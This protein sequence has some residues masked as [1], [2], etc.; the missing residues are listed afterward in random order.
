MQKTELIMGMPITITLVGARD[1]QVVQKIFDYF[2]EVDARY[3]TYKDTSE[4][5][6]INA[7]LPRSQWS[8]EMKRVLKLCE[9][10][11]HETDGCFDIEHDGLIDPSGLVK[12]WA[13]RRA[14]EKLLAK[15]LD[16]FSIEAGG[17]IEVHG[18]SNSGEQ[19]RIGI[20]NPFDREQIIKV[21]GVRDQ[22]VATSGTYIRGQHIYDPKQGKPLTDIAS[23]TVI[24]PNIYEADRFAT[25]AFAMGVKGIDFIEKLKGFEGY[26]IDTKGIATMTSGFEEYTK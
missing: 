17:D 12:G 11:K 19:W 20:R 3:S 5:S 4:I 6:R 9:Q 13:I 15:G 2:R 25:A 18:S 21:V 23:L 16:N 10:T 22:G 24:G 14:A 7:G 8:D 26:M 1:E